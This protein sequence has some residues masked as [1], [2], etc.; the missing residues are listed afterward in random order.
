LIFQA[1]T[2]GLSEKMVLSKLHKESDG[3]FI[4]AALDPIMPALGVGT[5]TGA[6][7]LAVGLI[8]GSLRSAHPALF[9]AVSGAQWFGLGTTFWYTRNV[10][11]SAAFGERLERNEEF[12]C[13][14]V[15]GALAGGINGAFRSRSNVI[16]GAIVMGLMGFAGQYGYDIFSTRAAS[17][18]ERGSLFKRFAAMKWVPLKSLSNEEYER[19]LS[20]RLLSTEAE[21]ALIDERIAKLHASQSQLLPEQVTRPG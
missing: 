4:R 12:A 6:S 9:A 7:G 19:M 1:Y 21:I 18:P 8:T 15:A 3:P 16:P 10:I 2:L 17:D 14:T 11:G 13:S 5:F 20:E